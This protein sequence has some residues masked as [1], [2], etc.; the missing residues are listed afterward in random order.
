MVPGVLTPC[1]WRSFSLHQ[2]RLLG[3][4]EFCEKFCEKVYK[5]DSRKEIQRLKVLYSNLGNLNEIALPVS[6]NTDIY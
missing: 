3:K 4:G 5:M 1:P 2:N 6:I